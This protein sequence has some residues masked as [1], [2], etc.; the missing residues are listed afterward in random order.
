[1][2]KGTLSS[3]AN[4][5]RQ[6]GGD[7]SGLPVVTGFDGFVDEMIRAVDKRQS[8]DA[9][10]AVSDITR[11]S[12]QLAAA[13]GHSSL[14]EIVIT[15]TDPGGCA[16]NMG[17]GMAAMGLPV[18]TFATVGEP[19]HAAFAAYADIATLHSWGREPGRTL[20]FEFD[21]GKLMF[22]AVSQ[23]AEFTPQAVLR[24]LE[25]GTFKDACAAARLIAITDWTLYPHMTACWKVLQEEVFSKLP[26]KPRFFIDL[27][28]P[29]SRSEE[30]IAAM[31]RQLQGFI[32]CGPT[33]LGLNQNEANIV[34]RVLDTSPASA[35][36]PADAIAQAAAIRQSLGIDEVVVHA[37]AYAAVATADGS[38]ASIPG[39]VCKRPRKLTGAGDRFN[40]GYACAC[41]MELDATERLA[42]AAAASGL[43]VRLGRSA[44][45]T[46]LAAFIDQWASNSIEDS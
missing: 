38:Q 2:D 44:S 16:I 34:A 28:D 42:L 25:D 45:L 23:L 8:L 9:Y 6:R 10:T 39:P 12:E 26:A 29:V 40:A 22:S 21:D 20:A 1:M 19:L 14:R 30:D 4:L 41:L 36:N 18:S 13:A 37:V 46:E 5:L 7:L 24:R 31:L 11:F 32:A 17:D 15:R 3:L 43:Y 35:D 33:T 27:V